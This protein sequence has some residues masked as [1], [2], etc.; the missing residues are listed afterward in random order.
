[1]QRK[2]ADAMVDGRPL[3]MSYLDR[4]DAV[5]KEALEDHQW[6]AMK[7]QDAPSEPGPTSQNQGRAPNATG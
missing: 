7:D 3:W 5:L 2:S 4:V 6:M 1:M